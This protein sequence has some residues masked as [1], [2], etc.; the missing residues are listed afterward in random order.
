[1]WLRLK[2]CNSSLLHQG[3]EII[4]RSENGSE[5]ALPLSGSSSLQA[6]LGWQLRSGGSFFQTPPRAAFR[7]RLS[8]NCVLTWRRLPFESVLS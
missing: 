4:K 2:L 1:M 5:D 3:R 6:A 8:S 7:S